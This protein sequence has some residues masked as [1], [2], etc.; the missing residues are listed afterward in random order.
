MVNMY[1]EHKSLERCDAELGRLMSIF[2]NESKRYFDDVMETDTFE[3]LFHGIAVTLIREKQGAGD[4]VEDL[5]KI[6]YKQESGRF[7]KKMINHAISWLRS[8]HIIGYA[9]KSIDCDYLNIK[10]NDRFYFLDVGIAHYFVARAGADEATIRGI[11]AENFVYLTLLRQI[12]GGIAGNAPWF[13]TYGKTKGEL[14]FYVRSLLDYK[15][16][17]VEVKA[18]SNS[19]NTVTRLL[20][21]GK[22]DYIYYLKGDTYGGKTE[23]GKIWTVPL[24]LADRIVF[25]LGA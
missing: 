20:K 9:S 13:A 17:G 4:L 22:I 15:N 11:V 25:N 1:L 21:D 3:K 24:Y 14:D 2:T 5:S 19:G 10:E 6:V 18:G 16:Y 8:S 23:D 12:S 7:T